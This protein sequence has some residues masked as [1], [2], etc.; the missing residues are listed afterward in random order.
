LLHALGIHEFFLAEFENLAMVQAD[1][2]RAHKQE[3]TE[4][5]P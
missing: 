5:K 1:G 4:H 2:E 3:R